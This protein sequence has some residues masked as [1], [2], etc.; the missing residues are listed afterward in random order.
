MGIC[1]SIRSLLQEHIRP[2]IIIDAAHLKGTYL[3][4]NLLAIGM[5]GNNQI[6]P[7]VT[8]VSQGETDVVDGEL[9]DWAAAKVQDRM[10]KSANRIVNG[11]EHGEIYQLSGLPCGHAIAVC[12]VLGLSDSSQLAK[13]WFNKTTLKATYE[14]LIFPVGEVSSWET[15]NNIQVIEPPLMD[16]RPAGRPK[17]KDRIRSQG[18][19]PRQISCGRCGVVGHNQATCK[20]P[21]MKQKRGSKSSTRGTQRSSGSSQTQN[22]R[23]QN[24]RV[25][26]Q[27]SERSMPFGYNPVNLADP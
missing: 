14:P 5:D 12:R 11:I 15:P 27:G 7:L 16:R 18:E 20:Q 8:G 1:V 2:L 24:R 19:E 21:L 26:S 17:N 25:S 22:G 9:S 10:L 4:T 23:P 13:D 6:I 3:G